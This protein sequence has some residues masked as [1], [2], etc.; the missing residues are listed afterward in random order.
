MTTKANQTAVLVRKTSTTTYHFGVTETLCQEKV[1]RPGA[2]PI[3]MPI[4]EAVG[5]HRRLCRHCAKLVTM[6]VEAALSAASAT[7]LVHPLR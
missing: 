1:P 7:D 3:S 2:D 6:W 4:R 5:A